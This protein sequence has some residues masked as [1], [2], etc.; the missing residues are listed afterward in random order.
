MEENLRVL[1]VVTQFLGDAENIPLPV[2]RVIGEPEAVGSSRG[3]GVGKLMNT[4]A[5]KRNRGNRRRSAGAAVLMIVIVAT[6]GGSTTNTGQ[7]LTTVQ[8]AAAVT[9]HAASGHPASGSMTTSHG[10]FKSPVL[11]GSCSTRL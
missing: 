10:F 3:G 5:R 2:L 11:V 7:L 1:M 9:Q 6:F 4:Q 8:H